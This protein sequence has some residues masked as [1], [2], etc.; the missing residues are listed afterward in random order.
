MYSGSKY[1]VLNHWS[2][3]RLGQVCPFELKGRGIGVVADKEAF[4]LRTTN[5]FLQ[6]QYVVAPCLN[7]PVGIVFGLQSECVCFP[8]THKLV[9]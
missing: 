9:T 1:V 5:I 6:R 7:A 2:S 8:S 3:T 4:S